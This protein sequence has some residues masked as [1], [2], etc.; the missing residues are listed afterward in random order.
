GVPVVGLLP[1]VE[2]GPQRRQG[3]R[4]VARVRVAPLGEHAQ[5]PS[6][7]QTAL[8]RAL[9]LTFHFPPT[10]G[11]G[12]QRVVKLCRMLFAAGVETTVVTVDPS[13]YEEHGSFGA[14]DP[15]LEAELPAGLRVV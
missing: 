6:Q 5:S 8:M 11:S 3:A 13:A 12:V 9:L 7:T 10:G 1:A 15:S 4:P 2:Q 14:L